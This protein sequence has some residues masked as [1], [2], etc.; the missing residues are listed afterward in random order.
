MSSQWTLGPP[1]TISSS[2][3]W[4]SLGSTPRTDSAACGVRLRVGVPRWEPPPTARRTGDPFTGTWYALWSWEPGDEVLMAMGEMEANGMQMVKRQWLRSLYNV[5]LYQFRKT[6][7]RVYKNMCVRET[8]K[9]YSDH[10]KILFYWTSKK[11]W[12]R[13]K[14]LVTTFVVLV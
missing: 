3:S 1:S 5:T 7:I 8:F 10:T 9:Y 2:I 6:K 13:T 14:Y 4:T 11:F 12:H